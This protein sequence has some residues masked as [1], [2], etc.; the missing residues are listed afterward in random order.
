MQISFG[1]N[2]YVSRF[3]LT[4]MCV[5]WN[6]VFWIRSFWVFIPLVFSVELA[7]VFSFQ[8][9]WDWVWVL[10]PMVV[11]CI[12]W[13]R[14]LAHMIV[15]RRS[16][17]KLVWLHTPAHLLW[18]MHWILLHKLVWHSHWHHLLWRSI[19]IIA[20]HWWLLK[21]HCFFML[22]WILGML[23]LWFFLFKS[24]DIFRKILMNILLLLD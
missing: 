23:L 15:L 19:R 11:C 12:Y 4:V 14:E 21:L 1:L 16:L 6:K 8:R 10:V 2:K 17:H 24:N 20:H 3:W 9:C 5:I 13:V 18:L 7:I 22:W